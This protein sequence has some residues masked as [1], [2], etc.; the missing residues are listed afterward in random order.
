[1]GSA[2]AAFL[3]HGQGKAGMEDALVYAR[4]HDRGIAR[5]RFRKGTD[6]RSDPWAGGAPNGNRHPY[7][8]P[9]LSGMDDDGSLAFQWTDPMESR[10]ACSGLIGGACRH[11]NRPQQPDTFISRPV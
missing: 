10:S 8:G 3:Q 6:K 2:V 9:A 11:R 4:A 7:Q 1:M 5:R